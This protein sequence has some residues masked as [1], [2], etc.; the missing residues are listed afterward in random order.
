MGGLHC[1]MTLPP[2][3]EHAEESLA[4]LVGLCDGV[5]SADRGVGGGAF[6]CLLDQG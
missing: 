5:G 2:W 4:P 3:L 1:P 6:Q